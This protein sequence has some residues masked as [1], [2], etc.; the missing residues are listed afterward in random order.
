MRSVDALIRRG[1]LPRMSG[2]ASMH[3][4]EKCVRCSTAVSPPTI[5]HRSRE[6]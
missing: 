1:S 6:M 2:L 5:P 3:Q 4:N